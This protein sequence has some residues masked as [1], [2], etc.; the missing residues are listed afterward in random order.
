MRMK[1][2]DGHQRWGVNWTTSW[3]KLQVYADCLSPMTQ[4]NTVK[5]QRVWTGKTN[6][7]NKKMEK[8]GSEGV[9]MGKEGSR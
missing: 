6:C 2:T 9:V 7:Q 1:K 3:F 8:R 4:G 5:R